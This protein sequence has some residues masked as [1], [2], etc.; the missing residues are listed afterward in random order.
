M[1]HAFHRIPVSMR[2]AF[3]SGIV[4]PLKNSDPGSD[5]PGAPRRGILRHASSDA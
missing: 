1:R 4:V 2:S 3:G 5:F